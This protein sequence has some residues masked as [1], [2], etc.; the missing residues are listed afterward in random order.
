MNESSQILVRN[1][2]L[3]ELQSSK[4][5]NKAFSL[6]A[7]ANRLNM[8]SSGLS[9]ILNGKRNVSAKM[10]EKILEHSH[11]DALSKQTL[12][13]DFVHSKRPSEKIDRKRL[14]LTLDQH[15]LIAGWEHFAILSLLQT[16]KCNSAP[17]WIARRLQLPQRRATE[18]IARLLRAKLIKRVDSKLVPNHRSVSTTDEIPSETVKDL[19]REILEMGVEKL[20]KT[21]PQDR[22]Y[23]HMTLAIDRSKI[24]EAKK[25]IR[26]FY[27]EMETLLE[28]G[29][30]EDVYSLAV[31]LIPI[32]TIGSD[33]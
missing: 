7:L 24:P 21:A 5:K 16:S 15:K 33:V 29:T 28:R 1:F 20:Y 12:K 14:Q 11:G 9:E 3:T 2:L 6:R 25:R 22:D 8:P 27:R 13:T 23:T 18:A 32:S 10:L 30:K 19:H 4:A 17:A 31:Q 26:K